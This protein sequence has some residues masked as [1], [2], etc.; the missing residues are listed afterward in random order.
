MKRKKAYSYLR[1]SSGPQAKG[2]SKRR[3][4]ERPAQWAEAN[5]FELDNSLILTDEGVSGWTGANA[6]T[7]KLSAF[8]EAVDDGRVRPG[9]ALIVE[10]LDRLT[11]QQVPIALEL[12]LSLLRRGITIVTL[13]D[14]QPDVFTWE[15]LSEVQLIIAIVILS[16]AHGESERKSQFGKAKW[17]ARRQAM[18]EGKTV[19]NLCP[20]WL[21][22]KPDRSGFVFVNDKVRTVRKIVRLYLD[23]LGAHLIA[24]KLNNGGHAPLGH[25]RQWDAGQI[26]HVLTHEALIGRKQPMRFDTVD[27][28]RV[29]VPDGEPITDYFP[30]VL[31][32]Q[33]WDR[34]QYELSIRSTNTQ[35]RKQTVRN[36]FPGSI[37]SVWNGKE[38]VWKL[39]STKEG[40]TT[41]FCTRPHKGKKKRYHL[42]YHVIERAVLLHLQEL[43]PAQLIGKS[44]SHQD[45]IDVISGRI[46]QHER[47]LRETERGL[48]EAYS[49]TLAK[50]AQRLEEEIRDGQERLAELLSERQ[51]V[52]TERIADL[53]DLVARLDGATGDNLISLRRKLKVRLQTLIERLQI[54]HVD[55]RTNQHKHVTFQ[56][57]FRGEIRRRFL[58]LEI[59][60]GK[61]VS[62]HWLAEITSDG[63]A[64]TLAVLDIKDSS[65]WKSF[66][67]SDAL[68]AINGYQH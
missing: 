22:S 47:Q 36:L 27:G 35:P 57:V 49:K 39:H 43:D 41:I 26:K 61:L 40:K 33:T 59:K 15:S 10:N 54:D 63:K 56:L 12:F 67:S 45:Q 52:T 1:F 28:R 38:S 7:G 44:A 68:A 19:G 11:R 20:R 23:G 18:R 58:K 13:S 9:S 64:V 53:K 50:V 24:E 42:P 37:I 5:G 25:G 29:K 21:K 3:Q 4:S 32:E 34:L 51:N 65:N 48:T 17:R 14:A 31:D 66:A 2:D 6:T 62:C 8:I 55:E 60:Q 30:A 16:R 46:A